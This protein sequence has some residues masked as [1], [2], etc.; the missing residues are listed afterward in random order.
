MSEM[1]INGIDIAVFDLHLLKCPPVVKPEKRVRLRTIPGRSGFLSEW[2]GDYEEYTKEPEFLYTGSTPNKAMN[3]LRSASLVTFWNEQAYAYEV[4]AIEWFETRREKSGVHRI[5]VPYLTQPLKRLAYEMTSSGATSYSL[6]NLGTEQAYP[7]LVVTGAGEQTV[8]CG[9][10]TI[11]IDFA[12]GGET[13][14]IDSLNG[15]VYDDEG[16]NA[17]NKLTGDLPV[18]PVSSSEITVSTTGS[19][20]TIYPN[21]RWT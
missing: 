2:N 19:A 17:W 4:S 21:W 18:I 20:L 5:I 12:I 7:K 13:I 10:T 8:T 3:F 14:I 11:T 9:S 15:Q 16:N 1:L 6:V